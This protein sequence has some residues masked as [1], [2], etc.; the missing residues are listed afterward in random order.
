M[1]FRSAINNNKS[2]A[3][4]ACGS[5]SDFNTQSATVNTA[6]AI[7][8]NTTDVANNIR[9]VKDSAGNFTKITFDKAGV[10]NI[11]WSGQFQNTGVALHDVSIWIKKGNG[12]GPATDISGSTGLVSV[13]NTHGGVH[14]HT[15]SAWNYML[16][17]NANDYLQFYWS[18]DYAGAT[19]QYY[20]PATTP[21]RP[22]TA[23]VIVT[24]QAISTPIASAGAGIWVMYE[25]GDPN[26]PVWIGVF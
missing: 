24:A 20:A 23:S 12:S 14:G 10:Y 4:V 18:T 17:I 15:I 19:L 11:Q 1:L 5:F 21:T 9:V 25:G 22:S 3:S 2:T 7:K 26:F 16:N 13:P 6:T 8:L